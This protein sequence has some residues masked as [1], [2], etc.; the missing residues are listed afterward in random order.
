MRD[1]PQGE[2]LTGIAWFAAADDLVGAVVSVTRLA[3]EVIRAGVTGA[4]AGPAVL[5]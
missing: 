1:W 5:P 2:S 4:G 3:V